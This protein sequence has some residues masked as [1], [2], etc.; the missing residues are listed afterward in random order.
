MEEIWKRLEKVYGDTQLNILTVKAN[1]ENLAPKA[2]ENYKRVLEVF[3]AVE[4]AVTQLTNL[5]AL[6]YIMEDFGLMSKIILK[7][8]SEYQDQF[9][10]YITSDSVRVD[11]SSRWDKFWVWMERLHRRSVESSLMNMCGSSSIKSGAVKAVVPTIRSGT[12]CNACGGRGHYARDCFSKN[13]SAGGSSIVK[14]NM[15]VA[16]ITTKD[17]YNQHLPEVRKQLGNCPACKQAV[18]VYTRQFPFGKAEWPSRRLDNCPQFQAKTVKERGDLIEKLKGCYKCTGWLHGGEACFS[19]DKTNCTVVTGGKACA[20]LHHKL[21]HGSGVAFCHKTEVTVA[22]TAAADITAHGDVVE[23][24]DGLPRLTQHVLLEVQAVMVHDV[25]SKLMWDGG[26][27]GALVTHDFAERAGLPG[28]KIAY[29]LAVVGHP[30]VLRHTTLYTFTLVDNDEVKHEVQAYGIDQISE[31]TVILDLSGVKTVFPGAPLEVY[32]RPDGPIDVLIGSMYKNIQPY[33]GGDNFTRGRL[34]MVKSLFGCGFILTGTHHAIAATENVICDHANTLVNHAT[35][36]RA[37]EEVDTVPMVSCN[38]AVAFLKLPEFFEAEEMGVSVARSCKRCRG[39]RECSYRGIMISRDKEMVVKRMEDLMK[40]DERSQ[41]VSVTY[42]WTEDVC[43]LKDNIGQAIAYQSSFERK[44][45]RDKPLLEAYNL[46]LQKAMDRGAIVRLT[47]ED[48][49]NYSGPVSYVAHHG[50]HKPDS[51]TTPLRVVTNTSLKNVKAGL[52]PN[53]CMQEGPNA[54]ASLLE[55]LLGFRMY[56]VALV[57]D[58]TKAYQSIA[59]GEVEKNCRR[60]VWRWGDTS[61]VWQVLAYNVVTFGDQIAGL[62]L[63]LVKKL[64]ADLGMEI[65]SDACHQIRNKTYVDDGAGGG[66][67]EQVE[68]FR[69]ELVDGFYNGTLARILALVGLKL[70]VMVAS[71]DKDKEKLA[72]MGE[73]LLGHIWRATTDVLVFIITV[74][75]STSKKKGQ[76][77]GKDLTMADIPELPTM[78]MTKRMLLGFV[79]SQYDP[80]GLICPLT[81]I[82]KIQLRKLY[83]P[84][85]DLGWDEPIPSNLHKEWVQT[86]TMCLQIGEIVFSRSVRP[87]GV[88]DPP[89]LIGFADGS[90]LAYACAIYIRW[91]KEKMAKEDPDRYVVRLVCGKARV[92]SVRGTTAP[93]SEI[94]GFLILTRLLKVV[95]NAMDIKPEQITPVVDSQCTISALEKSGGLLAPYFASRVSEAMENL[96]ELAEET[97]VLPVQHVPGPL[98]PADIPTRDRTGPDEVREGSIWQN[99]P[100]YLSL[101]REQWP[102]SREFLDIVPE[103]EMR[104]PKAVFNMVE[105]V[106]GVSDMGV[107]MMVRKV[108]DSSNKWEKTVN[109]TARLVRGLLAMNRGRITDPLTVKDI[110][111]ARILQFLVSMKPT[112]TSMNK[113]ELTSL[114]PVLV[115]GIVYTSGRCGR[116]LLNLLGI[117]KMP[118]LARSTRLAMLIMLESHVEDHRSTPSDVLARSRQR[119]WIIRGRYL[120]KQ[121]CKA[122]PLCKLNKR[123]LSK[124]LMADIPEHQLYPCPPFTYVSLDFAGPYQARAM[125]NSRSF[126]KLWGLVIICQNTRAVKMYATA[127]YSTD[128]FLTAYHRFT[129][130]HANPLMVVSDAGS[131]M[132]KAGEVVEKGDPAGLDWPRIVEGAAKSGTNWKCVEP[133]CQWRNGLAEAAVKLVKTT[134]ALTIAS[135][136]TLNYAELDTLFSSVANIVNQRPIAV[137]SFTEENCH[138]ITPND[139][140]LQ[141]SKNTV[142]GVVY[143]TDDSLTRRQEVMRELEQTW[144]DMWIVQA[145]PHLVP[146]KKWKTEYRSLQVGDIVLVLYDRKVGKGI[147]KLGR[148]LDVHPDSHG[149]TRTVTVGMRKTD[150]R[151]KLLPYVP[152]PLVEVK[153][154]VQR[155]AVICPVEE[156]IEVPDREEQEGQV[157]MGMVWD[158]Q[159]ISEAQPRKDENVII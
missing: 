92:T 81:I 18:H 148:V 100:A 158:E 95:V 147:Y 75:L 48:L 11:P 40:Y 125:G 16:K 55:V 5:D 116:A 133:G 37:G 45:I 29:W 120:A 67:R 149:V 19:R 21:L 143:G 68:R 20:G 15:A 25:L 13:K 73:K 61:A 142:P 39:C 130:N 6:Q 122:C 151:E 114:R 47:E 107:A 96:S 94:S 10:E 23:N 60:I 111:S 80:M 31:D 135:Q 69:G 27:S 105:T 91:K 86:I 150:K 124:Q 66:T 139:L 28:E 56:E 89:E 76:R 155:V 119:A 77:V 131:Q 145:L 64:A 52:S 30:K 140:L 134:L 59:T 129:A 159:E 84:D 44:L 101:P 117:A 121:V 82:L 104:V 54:L 41:R 36:A 103:E 71:G 12:T 102:F 157:N 144:W 22:G 118:I 46:E 4:T 109:V 110:Q 137:Q 2:T 127:G 97:V 34:R 72:L 42:P 3:E 63:E 9:A 8:P 113:G 24:T 1:L 65:D 62:I 74:N 38:R 58:M 17:E 141:R 49:Q 138:A 33:G 108:M 152:K 53:E 70:K 51:T 156:Q 115:D 128:D 7:L 146:F 85:M 90:L 32:N 87:A 99:G 57:Y 98:N 50:V 132:K 112:I 106:S 26:S 78:L 43:K 136:S 83:G 154:G 88:L 14:I 126:I 79:M 123:K 153:L 35:L 93:R